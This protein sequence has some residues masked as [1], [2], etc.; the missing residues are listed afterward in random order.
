M[1]KT[2]AR[3]RN[4]IVRAVRGDAISTEPVESPAGQTA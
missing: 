1:E 2:L 3:L 4:V